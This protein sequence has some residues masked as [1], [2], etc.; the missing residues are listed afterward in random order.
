[1][2]FPNCKGDKKTLHCESHQ[3]SGKECCAVLFL[4][5]FFGHVT[6]LD[7]LTSRSACPYWHK[8]M[9]VYAFIRGYHICEEIVLAGVEKGSQLVS[10]E[11]NKDPRSR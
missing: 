8:M 7:L 3:S 2:R 10:L 1:M 4:D 6:W 9:F 5:T 11:S